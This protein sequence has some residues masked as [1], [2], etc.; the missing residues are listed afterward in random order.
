[1]KI[2]NIDNIANK[3]KSPDKAER[4]ASIDEIKK[5]QKLFDFNDLSSNAATI[6]NNKNLIIPEKDA[7]FDYLSPGSSKLKKLLLNSD[8]EVANLNI[9]NN[10]DKLVHN[11]SE[12]LN[13]NNIN[14]VSNNSN[15]GN[16]H[17][18]STYNVLPLDSTTSNVNN[19]INNN[20]SSILSGGNTS[21]SNSSIAK[22]H[23]NSLLKPKLSSLENVALNSV[24]S[25]NSS[26][27]NNIVASNSCESKRSARNLNKP[28]LFWCSECNEYFLKLNLFNHMKSV[29]NKFTC[30]YCFGFFVKIESL[31][32]HLVKKHKVQNTSFS[33]E[34]TLRHYFDVKEDAPDA[35][36]KVIKAV[37]CKC[38][39]IFIITD[40]NFH[41]HSCDGGNEKFLAIKEA[42]Q[43]CSDS[44]N[45]IQHSFNINN[46]NNSNNSKVPISD[47]SNNVTSNLAVQEN[48]N[49]IEALT[50]SSVN[51]LNSAKDDLYCEKAIQQWLQPNIKP[52]FNG[53]KYHLVTFFSCF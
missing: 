8:P 53:G 32:K 31:E 4:S 6:N 29:H 23:T 16:N 18:G 45:H 9:N 14:N 46:N 30:L 11:N 3:E 34:Q 52:I 19:T 26:S 38:G 36:A 25:S 7:L 41:S 40:N 5:T 1:M 15:V 44:N 42:V 51:Q 28:K 21:S 13:N 49:C 27:N 22:N 2:D 37:C 10:S 33:D 20:N 43:S 24:K 17:S 48:S 50:T 39:S 47:F 12:Y 35:V